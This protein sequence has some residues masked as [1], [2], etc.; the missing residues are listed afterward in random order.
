MGERARQACE[1][2][3]S[4]SATTEP[5]R[6][7][8][9]APSHAPDFRPTTY[10]SPFDYEEVPPEVPRDPLRRRRGLMRRL[11]SRVGRLLFG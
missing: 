2:D 3:F 9:A 10:R 5:L 4:V 11:R 7:W 1:S 6:H 8:A